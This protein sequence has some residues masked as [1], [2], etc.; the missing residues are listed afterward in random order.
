MYELPSI[1]GTYP[2]SYRD[3]CP[4][5]EWSRFNIRQVVRQAAGQVPGPVDLD[6]K[7]NH[8]SPLGQVIEVLSQG[9]D[10]VA[11]P[12]CTCVDASSLHATTETA[13][14]RTLVRQVLS[15]FKDTYNTDDRFQSSLFNSFSPWQIR[16]VAVQI[17]S[18]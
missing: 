18:V 3:C 13:D 14:G 17:C 1:Q 5:L 2:P 12:T 4:N 7:T 15:C 9:Q 6:S 10:I 8:Q 16:F 11:F